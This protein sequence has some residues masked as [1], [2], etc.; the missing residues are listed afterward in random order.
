VLSN[1]SFWP[2]EQLAE[3]GIRKHSNLSQM[4]EDRRRVG[5]ED[6]FSAVCPGVENLFALASSSIA[7]RGSQICKPLKSLNFSVAARSA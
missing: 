2:R 7:S 5:D 1:E 4:L 3:L 6:F